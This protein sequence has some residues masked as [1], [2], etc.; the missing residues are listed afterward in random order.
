MGCSWVEGLGDG[1]QNFVFDRPP[2]ELAEVA[3]FIADQFFNSD[4][5]ILRASKGDCDAFLFQAFHLCSFH[6]RIGLMY[7]NLLKFITI[8]RKN[9]GCA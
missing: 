2:A 4:V 7:Y 9:D 3:I 5:D 8:A 1:A 6:S